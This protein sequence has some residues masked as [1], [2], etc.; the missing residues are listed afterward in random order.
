MTTEIFDISFDGLGVGKY[1]DKVIFIPNTIIGDVVEFDI[2]KE[3]KNFSFGKV[4]SFVAKSK[5]RKEVECPFFDNCGGCDFLNLDEY[6]E[7]VV[8]ENMVLNRLHRAFDMSNADFVPSEHTYDF[9]NYRNKVVFQCEVI[10]G[11]LY[12]G[13]Y[14]KGTNNLIKLTS[15]ML[16]DNIFIDVASNLI[17]ELEIILTSVE[18]KDVKH[19]VLK[20]N[21]EG[22]ILLGLVMR[23]LDDTTVSKLKKI[24]D[25]GVH[26]FVVN[27]N[28][29]K[30][31]VNFGNDTIILQGDGHIKES[32]FSYVFDISLL[33][34][35]Q[36]NRQQTIHL[37]NII[38][39]F[40]KSEEVECVIDGY[41]GV[42]TIAFSIS[43][44][45][46]KVIGVESLLPAYENA[47]S[48]LEKSDIKNVSFIHGKFEDEIQSILDDNKNIAIILDPPRRGCDTVVIES[49]L[50]NK[51]DN[52]VYVSCDLSGFIKDMTLLEN[53]YNISKFSV[54][55]MFP[56][57]KN[58]E[59][60][61]L[62][63]K[64]KS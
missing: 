2:V 39:D 36:V 20:K 45:F 57:T 21:S 14:E 44:F 6:Q 25:L 26:T 42:G 12:F 1:N 22:D 38:C 63:K 31:S 8:K 61:F 46:N 15:C 17:L 32:L 52:V 33:S 47:V 9:Y 28:N 5:H 3:K 27:V 50:K 51:I 56:R 58:I 23:K 55:N 35:F 18:L 62:L 54:V 13:F 59:S 7:Q 19:I 10:K 53:E 40:L 30:N 49:I 29:A 37:Y 41:C 11:K 34:F 64:N 24:K 43:K 4:L 48:S 60:V 16:F